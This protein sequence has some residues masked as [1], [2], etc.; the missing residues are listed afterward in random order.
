MENETWSSFDLG[1]AAS[2]RILG[3]MDLGDREALVLFKNR[4]A[5][6]DRQTRALESIHESQQQSYIDILRS[7]DGSFWI[8]SK[9]A[10]SS[11]SA[12]GPGLRGLTR[13]TE[14]PIP[15]ALGF[16]S[17]ELAI[18]GAASELFVSGTAERQEARIA[19]WLRNGQWAVVT[20][21]PSARR[22]LRHWHDREYW[23][24]ADGN[25]LYRRP[26]T[27]VVD[28]GSHKKKGNSHHSVGSCKRGNLS[29]AQA[30]LRS[31]SRALYRNPTK[32]ARLP[33][34]ARSYSNRDGK[35]PCLLAP[36][37]A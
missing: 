11:F 21:Q 30:G 2:N 15:A 32:R 24:M 33:N 37:S 29:I 22:S 4:L 35:R 9:N 23:W 3:V 16:R 13:W 12:I 34:I 20:R 1:P 17:I 26:Y 28:F 19:L 8:I 14:R 6:F 27:D 18:A 25:L 31:S 7:P 36:D 5:R 10:I